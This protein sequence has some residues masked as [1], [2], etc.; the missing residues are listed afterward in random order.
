VD[1]ALRA[2]ILSFGP[3]AKVEAPARLAEEI[4]EQLEEAR[5]AYAP[6]L[7]FALPQR[8]FAIDQPRLPGIGTRPS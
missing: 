3:F 2:W 1:Y 8:V 5:E 6:R 7:D 4:F